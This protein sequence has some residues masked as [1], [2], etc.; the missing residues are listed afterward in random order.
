M[1]G[2]RAAECQSLDSATAH[3]FQS[4]VDRLHPRDCHLLE[5]GLDNVLR[6]SG[7]GKKAWLASVRV[8]R[9]TYMDQMAK[10]VASMRSIMEQFLSTSTS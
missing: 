7:P 5:R 4:G 1:G 10:E 2:L 8:T 6:L 9:D 3:Q